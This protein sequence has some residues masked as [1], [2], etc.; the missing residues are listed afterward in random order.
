MKAG[1]YYFFPENLDCR[2]YRQDPITLEFALITDQYDYVVG[3]FIPT[4]QEQA[5]DPE[6]AQLGEK[7]GRYLDQ[8]RAA[9]EELQ[10]KENSKIRKLQS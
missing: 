5:D 2:L 10:K 1:Y 4:L 6:A 8:L 7:L 3:S 9:S